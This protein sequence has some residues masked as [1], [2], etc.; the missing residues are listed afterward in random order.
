MRTKRFLLTDFLFLLV[1]CVKAQNKYEFMSIIYDPPGKRI[2]ISIDGD[3]I[4]TE[5]VELS[6]KSDY[7][8][9]NT[10]PLLKK[11][12]EQQD[13]DWELMNFSLAGVRDQY[14]AFLRKKKKN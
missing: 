13:K 7:Y 5:T 12:K 11:V 14:I 6:P 1:L 2:C 4:L 8:H 9:M 10:N 3:T